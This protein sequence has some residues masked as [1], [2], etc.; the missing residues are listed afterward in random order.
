MQV[1]DGSWSNYALR[2]RREHL[3]QVQIC[4]ILA[5][6]MI[7]SNLCGTWLNLIHLYCKSFRLTVSRCRERN[8]HSTLCFGVWIQ[9][10]RRPLKTPRSSIGCR[11]TSC[12]QMA[13]S[14][15][16]TSKDGTSWAKLL[17]KGNCW[18]SPGATGIQCP[19]V[20]MLSCCFSLRRFQAGRAWAI[21]SAM[22]SP[23]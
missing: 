5:L 4:V 15:V 11:S 19:L 21:G 8:S 14:R 23:Y 2:I 1:K 6:C 16:E 10:F 22:S 3:K 18:G 9:L 17:L 7:W 20:E 13:E 12:Y